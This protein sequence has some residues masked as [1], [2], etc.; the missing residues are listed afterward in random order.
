MNDV[1]VS[2]P[3]CRTSLKCF[4]MASK[5]SKAVFEDRKSFFRHRYRTSDTEA[6]EAT[7]ALSI[8]IP[9]IGGGLPGLH[10]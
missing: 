9:V 4:Q 3:C 8:S 2:H 10:N 1:R 5:S 6:V 7:S